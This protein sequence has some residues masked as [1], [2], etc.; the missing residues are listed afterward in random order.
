MTSRPPQ[1]ASGI[2]EKPRPAAARQ[3]GWTRVHLHIDN[4]S[5]LGEVFEV[6]PTRLAEALKRHPAVAARLDITMEADGHRFDEHLRTADVLFGWRFDRRNLAQRAPRLRWIHAP[7]AG[8]NHFIPFDWLPKNA[9][10]TNNRGIHGARAHEYAIMAILMLNN[11]L[12]E[13]MTNQRQGKWVQLFNS[14]IE[15]KTLLIIGVGS[16]GSGIAAWAKRFGMYVIGIR[17]TGRPRRHVDEMHR[18]DA[19]PALLPRADFVAVATPATSQTLHLLGRK[20]IAALKNGAGL[21]NYSRAALVD[22]D[23]L[24]ERLERREV[25][26]ILDVFDPEPLPADSP[27]WRTPNLIISF[28]ND[29]ATTEIYTPKTLDLLFRQMERFM[30]G[31]KLANIVSRELEY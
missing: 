17:R 4:D 22:Y 31:R 10:F 16:V 26:A 5:Q 15:G 3:V 7:G 18:P 27:L 13:M 14:G 8:I 28:L 9:V 11:R 20:E 6:T 21:L 23:A 2:K 29:T 24:R 19:L 30:A 12:P 25:S 1:K